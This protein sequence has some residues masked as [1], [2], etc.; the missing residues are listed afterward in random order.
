MAKLTSEMR[1]MFEKQLAVIATV[2][3]DGRYQTRCG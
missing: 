1:E 3:K 2:S